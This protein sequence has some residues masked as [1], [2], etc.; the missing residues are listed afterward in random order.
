[1]GEINDLIWETCRGPLRFKIRRGVFIPD[2]CFRSWFV[3]VLNLLRNTHVILSLS[4]RKASGKKR[5]KPYSRSQRK[6][7]QTCVCVHG[8]WFSCSTADQHGLWCQ[9]ALGTSG[10]RGHPP[11][12]CTHC[13]RGGHP[14]PAS[15]LSLLVLLQTSAP[16]LCV[17]GS[18]AGSRL[19]Y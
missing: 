11:E 19:W 6:R 8:V 16:G 1:M 10:D 18:G 2:S 17:L 12:V 15:G 5:F 13:G 4:N 7:S 3:A 9:S 14:A